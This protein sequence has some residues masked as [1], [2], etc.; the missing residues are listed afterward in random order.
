MYI[1]FVIIFGALLCFELT[2]L[3][4]NGTMLEIHEKIGVS[5]ARKFL[6]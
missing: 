4:S 3:V 1:D 5:S 2:W 6:I